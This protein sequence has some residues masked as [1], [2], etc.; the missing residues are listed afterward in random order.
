[1]TRASNPTPAPMTHAR[2]AAWKTVSGLVFVE[3]RARSA[4]S[5]RATPYS[6]ATTF[7][8]PAGRI[9]S[10]IDCPEQ[11]LGGLAERPVAA[12]HG[13]EIQLGA[14]V[15]GDELR[16]VTGHFRRDRVEDEAACFRARD[17]PG[18]V[19]APSGSAG[20]RVVDEDPP[21]RAPGG[22]VSQTAI[23]DPRPA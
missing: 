16:R 19:D 18:H 2:P 3:Y 14:Q 23:P 5:A 8:V 20:F 11:R 1:M 15:R 6:R 10:G 4:T 13:D 21:P 9:A 7:V 17:D 12:R 22:R